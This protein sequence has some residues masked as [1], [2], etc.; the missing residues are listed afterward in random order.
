MHILDIL[1][2]L[3]D[4]YDPTADGR[5]PLVV[6][7]CIDTMVVLYRKEEAAVEPFDRNDS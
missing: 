3:H 6:R 1:D 7:I 4:N 5:S 2:H